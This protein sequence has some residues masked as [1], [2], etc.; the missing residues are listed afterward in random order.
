MKISQRET[1]ISQV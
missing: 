1:F